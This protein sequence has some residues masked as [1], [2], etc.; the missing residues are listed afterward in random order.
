MFPVI[1]T[2]VSAVGEG[3][4]E[5]S[6][7]VNTFVGDNLYP[8]AG[9]FTNVRGIRS[10]IFDQQDLDYCTASFDP[11]HG[12]SYWVALVPGP[13]NPYFGNKQ[14]ILQI[15]IIKCQN[16]LYSVCTGSPRYFWA[17]GGCGVDQAGP[18]DLGPAPIGG[19]TFAVRR[20]LNS[21]YWLTADPVTSGY[22]TVSLY[23]DDNN[24]NISCWAFGAGN[25]IGAQ[26]YC[27]RWDNG[28][29]CGGLGS[30]NPIDFTTIR[31]QVSVDGQ[32]YIPGNAGSPL[33]PVSCSSATAEMHCIDNGDDRF[34]TYVVQQ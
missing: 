5:N 10:Q 33:G 24:G 19:I 2:P 12:P 23:T 25:P 4:C 26:I 6:N 22:P 29:N 13:G 9:G 1:A 21:K 32:W 16:P 34:S 17:D 20:Q 28:D 15:G 8:P 31:F 27:E 18:V 7:T 3:A 11:G 14:A 30:S